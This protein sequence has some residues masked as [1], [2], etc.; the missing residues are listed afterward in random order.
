MIKVAGSQ[1]RDGPK[2]TKGNGLTEIK[3]KTQE[4]CSATHPSRNSDAAGG[5]HSRSHLREGSIFMHNNFC[6]SKEAAYDRWSWH[7]TMLLKNAVDAHVSYGK[8]KVVSP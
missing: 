1:K 8:V 5:W 2:P 4:V 3:T 6:L 7:A